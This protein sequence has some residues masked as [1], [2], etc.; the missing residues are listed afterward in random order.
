MN[1]HNSLSIVVSAFNEEK[2][3]PE[4]LESV[5]FAD[6]IIVVDNES[7]DATEQIA[8]KYK[9]KVFKK[10]NNPMLNTNKNIGFSKTSS[11]W[12][13]NLD[14]DERVTQ[15]LRSEIQE[16]LLR[17]DEKTSGF[18][19]PRKN[20]IFGKWMKH[21]GWYP[22][23]QLRL[24]RKEKG[25]FAEKHVHEK[26]EI[27]DGEVQRL[28]SPIYHENYDSIQQFFQKTFFI[29]APNEAAQLIA[30]GYVFSYTDAFRFPLKEF[31]G[32]FFLQKGYM[33]GFH[34]LMLSF[35]MAIYH[36]IVFAYLWEKKEFI[37]QGY[38]SLPLF[39]EEISQARKEMSYWI[40]NEKAATSKN[41]LMK[42]Y[43]MFRKR[44]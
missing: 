43:H 44:I 37:D 41:I 30:N 38:S 26:I 29:Y 28:H 5:A 15:E 14:A 13:L 19:I 21:A 3:L 16:T 36:E 22:D 24:F 39:Q 1:K 4:C 27:R 20:I 42:W 17:V 34:G 35:L 8:K 11:N 18:E 2:K 7:T 32:R 25:K 6:E 23:Y 33:D 12:I 31:L 10:P 40:N 9:A